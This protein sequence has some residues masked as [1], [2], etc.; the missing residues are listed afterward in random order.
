MSVSTED[1]QALP[2]A[3]PAAPAGQETPLPPRPDEFDRKYRGAGGTQRL[4]AD[5]VAWQDRVEKLSGFRP[6]DLTVSESSSSSGAPAPRT[7]LLVGRGAVSGEPE[8]SKGIPNRP[9]PAVKPSEQLGQGR[10]RGVVSGTYVL[11]W[12]PLPGAQAVSLWTVPDA[13]GP[14]RD[15]SLVDLEQRSDDQNAQLH[16]QERWFLP[17][18]PRVGAVV[19]SAEL[20]L[21]NIIQY[22][23]TFGGKRAT[24]FA[25]G[26]PK[27]TVTVLMSTAFHHKRYMRALR[28][29]ATL[30]SSTMQYPGRL[31]LHNIFQ[32]KTTYDT[33]DPS[34]I[35]QTTDRTPVQTEDGVGWVAASM[36]EG[37][38]VMVDRLSL[39]RSSDAHTVTATLQLTILEKLKL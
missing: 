23:Q 24:A 5:Y 36:V 21:S 1:F 33:L 30:S 7:G 28:M 38:H 37:F 31:V 13:G 3:A 11:E 22:G 29:A 12:V 27:M 10:A 2:P 34:R 39:S 18:M 25:D 17:F 26:F 20:E 8:G 6:G 15:L 19:T 14:G 9:H 4:K 35:R 32:H 16:A